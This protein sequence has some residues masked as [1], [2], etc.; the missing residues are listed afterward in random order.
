MKEN[1]ESEDEF[2]R[3]TKQQWADLRFDK[4]SFDEKRCREIFRRTLCTLSPV[5]QVETSTQT[6]LDKAVGEQMDLI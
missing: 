5:I 4:G 2:V 1:A 3:A 6:T